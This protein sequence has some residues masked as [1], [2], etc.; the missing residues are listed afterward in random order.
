VRALVKRAQAGGLR[1]V[2]G[3]ARPERQRVV[4]GGQA[5]EADHV[6]WACGAWLAE[7]FPELIPLRVTDQ[8]VVLFDAGP[9]WDGRPA[10][11]D[12]DVSMYGHSQIEPHGM[13]VASDR[14][15]E[16][17]T[18]EAARGYLASRF[19]AL[20]DAPV[21]STATCH[22]SLT[23]DGNFVFARHPEHERV[24][25]LG[26][27]SGHG[28][29]HGPALAAH[30]ADVLAGQAEPEPRFALGERIPSRALRTA[31]S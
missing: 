26:G 9:S 29:K 11:L 17:T 16:V 22:Y 25:L 8:Q 19:P 3:E 15:G 30:V 24:W 18:P 23:A 27:G 14:E 5:M 10:W 7:L 1:L 6:I 28:Y 2:R 4:V 31:G 12:F 20:A 21:R 13:K